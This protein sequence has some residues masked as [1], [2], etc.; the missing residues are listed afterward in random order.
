MTGWRRRS[1]GSG[2]ASYVA[3]QRDAKGLLLETPFLS[4]VAVAAD[5]YGFLPVGLLM[6]DQYHVDTWMPQVTEPVFVAHGSADRTIGVSHGERVYALAPNQAG[7]W[8]EAG[9]DHDDLWDR[10]IWERAKAFFTA[11]PK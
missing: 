9:A 3:S 7:I 2:P 10:G 11:L 1:L 6:Q 8:I 4:A 5:R